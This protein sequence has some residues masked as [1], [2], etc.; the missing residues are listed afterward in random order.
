M[1]V[2][3]RSD[4]R[5]YCAS[6]LTLKHFQHQ[7][8]CVCICCSHFSSHSLAD[9]SDSQTS[10]Q[11]RLGRCLLDTLPRL[12]ANAVASCSLDIDG[13]QVCTAGSVHWFFVVLNSLL[14]ETLLPSMASCS[15]RL[16]SQVVR[17]ME[18]SNISQDSHVVHEA[19]S[20]LGRR[21]VEVGFDM[22]TFLCLRA[23]ISKGYFWS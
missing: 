13:R 22:H 10:F 4:T 2:V 17:A 3:L 11:K 8:G 9:S 23:Y 12:L 14:S 18:D 20:I 6:L 1:C 5:L 19:H 21:Y 7:F 15:L 16:L